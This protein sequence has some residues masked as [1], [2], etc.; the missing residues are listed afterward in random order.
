[1]KIGYIPAGEPG[2]F[3][4]LLLPEVAERME[5]GEAIS[6]LA[7][8]IHELA[9]GAIAGVVTG[10]RMEIL[11]LYVAPEYRR[12]GVGTLLVETM[13]TLARE[14]S[15]GV[16]IS[17]TVTEEEHEVLRLFLE[18]LEFKKEE[19]YGEAIYLTTVGEL[20]NKILKN[21]TKTNAGV[22]FFELGTHVLSSTTKQAIH[23]HE[24]IPE[25]GLEAKTVDRD[26]SV[27]IIKNEEVVAY[28]VIDHSW[29]DGLCLSAISTREIQPKE[30]MELFCT[31]IARMQL[32]YSSETK[33][34]LPLIKSESVSLFQALLGEKMEQI[35]FTYYHSL[36]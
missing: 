16:E 4:S 33:I 2:I 25:G 14:S 22:S 17:F 15:Y 3:R 28:I 35:S 36:K 8:T 32:K 11:S 10:S 9:V 34:I 31:V 30:F 5:D 21:N 12:Q 7:V 19:D 6:A 18:T 13:L 23:L 1:M 26:L 20:S 24:Q 27:A 29:S